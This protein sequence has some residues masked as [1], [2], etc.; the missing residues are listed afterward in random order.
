[1]RALLW[2]LFVLL[3]I[4]VRWVILLGTDAWMASRPPG[5]KKPS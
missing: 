1:M 5:E 3:W 4:T 2:M